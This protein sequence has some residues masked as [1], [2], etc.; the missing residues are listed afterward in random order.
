MRILFVC[1]NFQPEPNFFYCLPL[2]K[3]FVRHGHE[4]EVLTGFPNYPGGKIYPGY[5]WKILQREVMEGVPLLRVPLYPSHDRSAFRR[6]VSYTSFGVSAATFGAALV[7]RADV[8]YVMQGPA[9]VGLPA[10]CLSIF[11]V[12]RMFITSRICGR[13][14]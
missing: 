5:R 8:A 9:T 10:L 11:A 3:E 13:T 14:P 4:V 2:M 7:H 6:I 12:C 1:H